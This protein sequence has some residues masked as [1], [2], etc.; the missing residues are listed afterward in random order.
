MPDLIRSVYSSGS[1][2]LFFKLFVWHFLFLHV[3]NNDCVMQSFHLCLSTKIRCPELFCQWSKGLYL[4]TVPHWWGPFSA[5]KVS[6]LINWSLWKQVPHVMF[7]YSDNQIEHVSTSSLTM[8]IRWV[9]GEFQQTMLTWVYLVV[10]C[11]FYMVIYDEL[12][13]TNGHVLLMGS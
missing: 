4:P 7:T 1:R 6:I 12:L 8:V 3:Q 9:T 11:T 5:S 10:Y 13:I 2:M